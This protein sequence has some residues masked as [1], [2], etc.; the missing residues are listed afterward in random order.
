[1]KYFFIVLTLILSATNAQSQSPEDSV[2]SVINNMFAAMKN[3]DAAM[4]KNCFADSIV[5][6]SIARN[7]EG[8]TMVR[9][10]SPAGFIEQISKASP[11]SLDERVSFETVKVDGPLAIAWTPYN[12]YYNGQFSHCGVNSF[13]LVRFDGVWKIQY[14]IDTRRKQGCSSE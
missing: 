10:E 8:V 13:Q 7:K 4:L 14:I 11:G 9:T 6:Q 2:K 5:F 3:A 1:M 12:F